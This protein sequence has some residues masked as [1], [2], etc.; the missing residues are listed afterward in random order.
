MLLKKQ[1]FLKFLCLLLMAVVLTGC[2]SSKKATGGKNTHKPKVETVNVKELKG[3]ERK[4]VEEALTWQ[5]TPY[6]YASSEKGKGTDCSGM[7]IG[8]YTKV[9]DKKLPRNS[10]QQAEF[11]KKLKEKDVRPGDLV[12]F[13]TGKDKYKISHVGIM[14]DDNRFIHASTQKGVLISEMNTPY[15]QRTFI[16]YG[17]V[18]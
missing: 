10:A 12:F 8:V 13:A 17:R 18:P 16:M 3:L 15:Y 1:S 5:G 7:V 2:H 11:C 9:T 6:K 14:L 4:I